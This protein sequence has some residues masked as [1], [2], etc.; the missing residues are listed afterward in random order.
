MVSSQ[1]SRTF[2]EIRQALDPCCSYIIVEGDADGVS[3]KDIRQ[4][5]RRLPVK[6]D[7]I[8]DARIYRESN[9]GRRLLVARLALGDGARIKEKL[10]SR[11]IAPRVAVYYY[12]CSPE[13]KGH[14]IER[15]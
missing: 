4:A 8:R 7:E 10:I 1:T 12:G 6:T 3:E 2:A 9:T 13:G 14:D 5:F 11:G 15:L